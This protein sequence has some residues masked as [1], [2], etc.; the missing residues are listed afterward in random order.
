V[1]ARIAPDVE[2]VGIGEDALVAVRGADQEE[3]AVAFGQRV[4]LER[5]RAADGAREHLRRGVVAQR[6]LDPADERG[7]ARTASRGAGFR[8]SQ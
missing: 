2:P 4:A 3:D 7:S 1:G 6:L 8:Q 5:D